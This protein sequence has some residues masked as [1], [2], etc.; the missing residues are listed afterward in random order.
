MN[1]STFMSTYEHSLPVLRLG[2]KGNFL[3]TPSFYGR[4]ATVIL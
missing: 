2:R 3:L 1:P 4:T